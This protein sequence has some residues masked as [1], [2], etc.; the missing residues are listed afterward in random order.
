MSGR[1]HCQFL[2]ATSAAA[3]CLSSASVCV[4]LRDPYSTNSC[5][6]FGVAKRVGVG[7]QD[8]DGIKLLTLSA[9]EKAGEAAE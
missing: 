4:S 7:I 5:V 9:S 2:S 3:T 1:M 6:L 8:F